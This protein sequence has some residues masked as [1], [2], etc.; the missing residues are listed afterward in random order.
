MMALRLN[1]ESLVRLQ[2]SGNLE[3]WQDQLAGLCQQQ[4]V[5]GYVSGAEPRIAPLSAT[6]V[7]RQMPRP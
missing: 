4:G 1:P 5:W 7:T 6:M 3:A 2:G